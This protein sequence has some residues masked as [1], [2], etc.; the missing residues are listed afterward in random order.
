MVGIL[1]RKAPHQFSKGHVGAL[2][3]VRSKRLEGLLRLS[4]RQSVVVVVADAH[5]A[6]VDVFAEQRLVLEQAFGGQL[7]RPALVG[8][9]VGPVG[10]ARPSA[11]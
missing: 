1:G 9:T 3:P 7:G 5:A 6:R 10:R 11:E 8:A 4:E 2:G